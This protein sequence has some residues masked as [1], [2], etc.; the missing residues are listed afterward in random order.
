MEKTSEESHREDQQ[1]TYP[2]NNSSPNISYLASTKWSIVEQSSS[3]T[4]ENHEE[5]QGG[6]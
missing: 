3:Q 4:D 1:T 6:E 5:D 2:S